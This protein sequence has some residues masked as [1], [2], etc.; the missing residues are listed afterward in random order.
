MEKPE[1]FARSKMW[2]VTKSIDAKNASTIHR[3]DTLRVWC[4]N[5][6]EACY[7]IAKFLEKLELRATENDPSDRPWDEVNQANGKAAANVYFPN[8]YENGE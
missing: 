8:H 2:F 6:W 1:T 7:K 4:Y 5:F 3:S